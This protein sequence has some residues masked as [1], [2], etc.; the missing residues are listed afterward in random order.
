MPWYLLGCDPDSCGALAVINGPSVGDVRT[1]QILDCP[2]EK[3]ATRSVVSVEKM[4]EL[5]EIDLIDGDSARAG[6][7]RLA[8]HRVRSRAARTSGAR[9]GPASAGGAFDHTS[10]MWGAA[11]A[12]VRE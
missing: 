6:C 12:R 4:V 3:H 2:R 1:I 11:C 8:R 5:T 10:A 7:A 9:I